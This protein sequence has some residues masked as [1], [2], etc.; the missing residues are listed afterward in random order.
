[1]ETGL[2]SKTDLEQALRTQKETGRRLGETLVVLGVI[3][4]AKVTQVLSQQL[5]VPWVSLS[6]ID[7]SRQLLNLVPGAIAE[8]YGVVPIYVRRGKNHQQT[9]YIAMTDPTD[10]EPLRE[11]EE[12][13]GLPVRPMIAPPT[14]VRSAIRVYYLG[15]PP[16]EAPPTPLN[17][18][19]PVEPTLVPKAPTVP[20]DLGPI[21][22]R[23]TGPL[24]T[25]ELAPESDVERVPSRVS[26]MP[27]PQ[28]SEPPQKMVTVTLL[29]GTQIK[30]PAV[31]SS[32]AGATAGETLTARD[33]VAALRA[34][35]AGADASEVLGDGVTWERMFAALLS[36]LLRKHLVQDWEFVHELTR[37]GP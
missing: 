3:S 6:H 31:R 22:Y 24:S 37:K 15:L 13:S 35:A 5:S 28:R 4:E 16:D 14:D 34:K 29:D 21:S 20:A 32:A 17:L 1:M 2:I 27:E 36:V 25:L 33:L 23:G 19:P 18:A 11:I 30:L 12:F 10:P 9:L 8:K 26:G 7:F